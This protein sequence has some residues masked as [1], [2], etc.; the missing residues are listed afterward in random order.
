MS[1]ETELERRFLLNRSN[2][3]TWEKKDNTT[4][5]E[6]E[7]FKNVLR[8]HAG[9]I[10]FG[11]HSF[12]SPL[13]HVY[14][15][16]LV[17]G[18]NSCISAGAI[19]RGH[20]EI[21][22]YTSINSF[23]HI[24]GK[25]KIGNYVRIAGLASIYGFNHGYSSLEQPIFSQQCTSKGVMIDDDVWIGANAV[26]IDGVTIAKHSIVAAGAVVTKDFPEY[27]I[28]GGNPAKLIRSRISER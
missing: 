13:A 8:R 22:N 15:D 6:N 9:A 25:I 7:V 18:D 1:D 17:I 23:A 14:T 10:S 19:V 5:S 4:Q 27:S 26:V 16:H 11:A 20:V 3:L 2:F 24:A 12:V 28:I 21:G